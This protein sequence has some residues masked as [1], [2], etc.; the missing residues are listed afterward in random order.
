MVAYNYPHNVINE[1][2]GIMNCEGQYC[3][4][5]PVPVFPTP[6]YETVMCLIL[7]GIL[8]ALRKRIRIPGMLFAIY[9]V[10]NGIERFLIE[11][12]R[13]NT[14][15]SIMGFHPTQ[16]ELISS[17]LILTGIALMYYFKRKDSATA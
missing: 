9:L 6:F 15:Y 14:E 2:I 12:I 8:W 16:A 11:K 4:Q 7:F 1:G 17:V 3:N 10:L 5:L 13:V